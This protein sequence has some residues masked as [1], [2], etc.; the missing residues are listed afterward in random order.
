MRLLQ[1][2]VKA[3]LNTFKKVDHLPHIL[4][5]DTTDITIFW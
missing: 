2:S 1:H 5:S 4:K 3:D